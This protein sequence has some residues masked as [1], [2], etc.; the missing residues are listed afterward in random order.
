MNTQKTKQAKQVQ[1][2]WTLIELAIVTA[3]VSLM[4]GLSIHFFGDVFN[5]KAKA[6]NEGMLKEFV[7]AV[8]LAYEDNAWQIESVDDDVFEIEGG[9]IVSTTVAN[10]QC[11]SSAQA[12]ELLAQYVPGSTLVG[13]KD[14]YKSD[15]CLFVSDPIEASQDGLSF[16][17]RNLA[18]VSIGQDRILSSEFNVQTG[19]LTLSGD[20]EGIV[21]SGRRIVSD[22]IA[23]TLQKTHR[24]S[25]MIES[26]QKARYEATQTLNTNSFANANILGLSDPRFDA[27]SPLPSTL[28]VLMDL[29]EGGL[30]TSLG[31]TDADVTDAWGGQ[32]QFDNSSNAV[33]HPDHPNAAQAVAPF[34]ARLVVS[35]PNAL[36]SQKHTQ[37]IIA[38]N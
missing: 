22:Q 5:R 34:S 10:G 11:A 15:L 25:R 6:V 12:F 8:H 14:G 24:L 29:S 16:T 1:G 38:S 4:A 30:H 17:Y 33:R 31:L 36:Q 3:I 13:G 2:G 20:D 32:I 26:I 23:Q 37:S 7:Q 9:S 21:A 27:D 28:G 35:I 18:L 19:H